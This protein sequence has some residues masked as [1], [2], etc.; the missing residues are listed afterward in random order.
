MGAEDQLWAWKPRWRVAQK[1][2]MTSNPP[3][4]ASP[5]LTL[6]QTCSLLHTVLS[7]KGLIPGTHTGK[8]T[9]LQCSRTCGEKGI[10]EDKGWG[11]KGG[12]C[13]SGR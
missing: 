6:S 11:V 2:R 8:S 9:P 5:D 13:C 1:V 4:P 10:L 3:H 7:V 12:F